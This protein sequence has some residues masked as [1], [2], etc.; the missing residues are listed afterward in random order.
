M[1]ETIRLILDIFDYVVAY[2]ALGVL[3]Y[4]IANVRRMKDPETYEEH[5]KMSVK[6][7]LFWPVMMFMKK[8]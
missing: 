1:L 3:V 2:I 5:P 4:F 8:K 7:I 6:F